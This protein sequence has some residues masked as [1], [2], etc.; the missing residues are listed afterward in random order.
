MIKVKDM[1]KIKYAVLPL[2]SGI[3]YAFLYLVNFNGCLGGKI[4]LLDFDSCKYL[5]D[6]NPVFLL[7]ESW[8]TG[9]SS[10]FRLLIGL[11]FF[12]ILIGMMVGLI[13]QTI[14]LFLKRRAETS[15]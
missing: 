3:F 6:F 13:L 4:H 8:I 12:P 5:V 15:E 9:W 1:K 10:T 2:I 7:K 11:V 14:Y